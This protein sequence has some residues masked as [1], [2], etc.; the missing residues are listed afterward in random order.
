MVF[1]PSCC[2]TDYMA[3]LVEVQHERGASGGQTFHSLLT[4]SLPPRRGTSPAQT[5][6]KWGL[7]ASIWAPAP[8]LHGPHVCSS[9]GWGPGEA[10]TLS[11]HLP[12]PADSAEAPKP[13]SSPE[14]PPGQ[15]RIR[16]LTQVRVLGPE[17]DLASV[18][19]QVRP[20]C[21]G[22]EPVSQ[23][24]FS[25]CPG[26]LDPE[27]LLTLPV[28]PCPPPEQQFRA[29]PPLGGCKTRSVLGTAQRCHGSHDRPA[30][31]AGLRP[32]S[33]GHLP[34][35][36]LRACMSQAWPCLCLCVVIEKGH[37]EKGLEC[38]TVSRVFWR[39]LVHSACSLPLAPPS[40]LRPCFPSS[41]HTCTPAPWWWSCVRVFS[42]H[43]AMFTGCRTT[44]LRARSHSLHLPPGE[45]GPVDG[46]LR[47]PCARCALAPELGSPLRPW[48]SLDGEPRRDRPLAKGERG[49]NG[50][51]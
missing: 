22:S 17:D 36:V 18:F 9:L 5:Q 7:L 20:H 32:G 50:R 8:A 6:G 31:V 39:F 34:S 23:L 4:A 27:T 12:L 3:H 42:P 47:W 21:W 48:P 25:S 16:A 26:G 51:G 41:W 14:P 11:R 28:S 13:K 40:L 44:F 29:G 37:S 30:A 33:S 1:I 10:G 35:C 2:F 15:G 49:R 19:L 46:G 24:S 38:D 43:A 45:A